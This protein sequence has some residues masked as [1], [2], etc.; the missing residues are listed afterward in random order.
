MNSLTKQHL[1][2]PL[3]L[4]TLIRGFVI[5]MVIYYVYNPS[6]LEEQKKKIFPL[7]L[8]LYT[9]GGILLA[10][11]TIGMSLKFLENTPNK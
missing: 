1:L 7:S 2:I 10:S 3:I 5:S 4:G 8:L 9:I 6:K 11:G